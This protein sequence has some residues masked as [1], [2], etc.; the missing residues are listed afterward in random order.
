MADKPTPLQIADSL[1]DDV[2]KEIERFER[3]DSQDQREKFAYSLLNGDVA[4]AIREINKSASDTPN[5]STV[6]A[7]AYFAAGVI[8]RCVAESPVIETYATNGFVR[9]LISK[10]FIRKWATEAIENFNKSVRFSYNQRA[11]FN[12]GVSYL[13]MGQMV[14]AQNAL[15][16]AQSG[17][18]PE[19]A[20]EAAKA[21]TR[22]RR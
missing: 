7:R 22:L 6:R 1:L 4:Q 17:D 20:M 3:L 21:L 16:K 12:I 19:I 9:D 5:I 15:E 13:L 14:D 8:C 10:K 2:E 18:E 11:Y